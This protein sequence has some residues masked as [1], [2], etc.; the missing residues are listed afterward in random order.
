MRV[1]VSRFHINFVYLLPRCDQYKI[2][3]IHSPLGLDQCKSTIHLYSE[4]LQHTCYSLNALVNIYSTI[5]TPL[6]Q[7][8]TIIIAYF[9]KK[10]RK[11]LVHQSQNSLTLRLINCTWTKSNYYF[12]QQHH[13]I[14]CH[15]VVRT[16]CFTCVRSA[17]VCAFP[18]IVQAVK[19]ETLTQWWVNVGPPSATVSQHKPSIG[20]LCLVW[21]N[22]E[23]GPASQAAGQH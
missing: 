13:V 1:K 12:I 14:M 18:P 19:H 22:A 2:K 16:C 6:S 21:R 4:Y 11:S 23:C 9:E 15:R 5:K 10:Q 8:C 20:L 3:L 17:C 7:V